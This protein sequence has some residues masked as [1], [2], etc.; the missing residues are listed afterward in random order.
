MTRTHTRRK[1]TGMTPVSLRRLALAGMVALLVGGAA[2]AET[3][4]PAQDDSIEA[5]RTRANAGDAEASAL[6]GYMYETGLGVPQDDVEAEAW[7]RQAAEQ[8][9]AASMAL[10]GYIYMDES[11]FEWG[12]PTDDIEGYKWFSLAATYA[13]GEVREQSVKMR[14]RIAERLTP[15]Q[16]T[17]AQRLAREWDEAHPRE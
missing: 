11:G 9:H 5:L 4:E 12:V 10:L 15:E 1:L 16:L 8:G 3:P 17:E 6:L 13:T 7:Y 14:D 2:C